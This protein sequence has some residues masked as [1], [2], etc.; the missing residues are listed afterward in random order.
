MLPVKNSR[1]FIFSLGTVA[2]VA[3]FCFAFSDLVGY[4][5]VAFILLVTVSVIAITSDILPV[6]VSAVL[7]AFL[8]NFFFIPPRFTFHVATNEDTILFFMY[9]I[10]A[11]VNGVLTFKIRQAEKITNAKEEKAKSVK[12][13]NTILDSLSHELRTPIAAITAATDNLQLNRNLSDE[14][15]DQLLA[16]I[17]RASLRLNQQVEN[18][19]NISRLESGHIQPKKD[20]CD[21]IELVYDVAKQVEENNPGRRIDISIDPGLPLCSLD[22]G[23]LEQ[24]IYNLLNNA[25]IHNKAGTIIEISVSCHADLLN[26]YI[27]DNGK[28]FTDID[29]KDIFYKFSKNRPSASS[30][31]GL[32]LSIVKGFTDAM[33]GSVEAT[34][35]KS[36]GILF[37]ITLPVKTTHL[38]THE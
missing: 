36:G 33:G 14:N 7:S 34:H 21:I 4:R 25:A 10:I 24:I 26:I 20:W 15:K 31:S 3:A 1:Q 16:E 2:L 13:Y 17:S 9:F 18:L 12:L 28:G 6:L 8:W 35:I 32:G 29:I 27:R 30:G 23:M 37:E 22:K 11:M 38:S 5:T 19:L